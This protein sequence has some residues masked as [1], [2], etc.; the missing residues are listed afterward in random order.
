MACREEQ[1]LHQ[2]ENSTIRL[3]VVNEITELLLF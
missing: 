2:R 3:A 1:T